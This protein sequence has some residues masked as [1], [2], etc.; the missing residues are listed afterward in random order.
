M[1]KPFIKHYLK[2]EALALFG[3]LLIM[4]GLPLSKF[5]LTI[6]PFIIGAAAFWY[7]IQEK[8]KTFLSSRPYVWPLV[9]LFL[10]LL[11]S[12]LYTENRVSWERDMKEKVILAGL[13]LS[14]AILPSFSRKGYYLIYYIFI[15][16]ISLTALLS[17]YFYLLDYENVNVSIGQNKTVDIV[18]NMHHSYFGFLQAFSILLGFD[19]YSRKKPI[20]KKVEQKVLLVL[21][22]INFI[23]LHLFASRTGMICFYAG[24]GAYLIYQLINSSK[25]G[26]LIAILGALIL[27]PII[28]YYTIPSFQNRVNVTRWDL[29]QYFIE[30]RDL[31]DKS[32]SQRLL[33]WESS[34]NIFKDSPVYGI[35]LADVEDE[36][37]K[38]AELDQ[39]RVKTAKKLNTPHNEYLEY[40]V[41]Y[42]LVGFL[43]LI[44]TCIFPLLVIRPGFG[45]LYA[46]IAVWMASMVFE[47]ILERIVGI[48]FICTFLMT[49]PLFNQIN[50]T[51]E[52]LTPPD[53]N[54]FP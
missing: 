10:L 50:E 35:G 11:I 18:G 6:S 39:I 26:A 51:Q 33:V 21:I 30:D 41:A 38:R 36:L 49:L 47:S 52:D 9:A 29:E 28:S 43:L 4:V 53:F 5:L 8:G 1:E 31:G 40:L 22:G 7:L 34:W 14:L 2:P 13:S 20:Y 54:Y 46:F 15:L 42:G 24:S 23:L 37:A 45:M 17:L 48:S 44:V 12:G 25:K 27:L 3:L 32:F 19:L 16:A